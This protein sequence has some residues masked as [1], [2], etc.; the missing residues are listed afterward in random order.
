MIE[1]TEARDTLVRW[2]VTVWIVIGVSVL[3]VGAIWLLARISAVLVPF[4]FAL[5][6]VFL[7]RR[8]V[9]ALSARGMSRASAVSLCYLIGALVLT[10]AGLFVIPPLVSQ[11]R[12][13][14]AAFPG[15]Y[16]SASKLWFTLQRE[17]TNLEIPE[18]LQDAVFA[19]R[20]SITDQLTNW[21]K[22]VATMA[23]GAGGRMIGFVVNVFLSLA[24]AFFVLKD[25]PA[26][27]EEILRLGGAK[28]RD[29]LIEV[30]GRVTAVVEGW[31]RGQSMIALI[32][33]VLTWFGLQVL[34]VPYAVI[35]GI[36]AGVTNLIPYV[37]PLVGGSIA[38]ISAAFVS[39]MLVVYTIVWIVILQQ[40]ESLVL[41]PRVM[42]DQVNLHPV[43]VIFSLLVGAQAGGLLG[44]LLAVP[45][46]GV[47]NVL[48]IYYFEKHTASELATEQGALFRKSSCG[49]GDKDTSESE[50]PVLPNDNIQADSERE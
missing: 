34:G 44:M 32:V 21:S 49:S 42:S 41:Q 36:I 12:E 45:V 30:L 26:L 31:L 9:A 3:I 33:G 14:I 23:I 17:Y 5:L 50:R 39:P 2:L 35:I 19:A 1:R 13:F 48:F 47:I 40:V 11:T 8:P 29:T 37:G 10:F 22:A 24:L 46:A 7:L 27:K 18:W 20:Q 38:A 43:L 28:R 15:Y 6:V 4:I 25:L 16:E